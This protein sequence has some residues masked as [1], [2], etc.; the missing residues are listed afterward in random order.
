[1]DCVQDTYNN[2]AALLGDS[3]HNSFG[4]NGQNLET[5]VIDLNRVDNRVT[6]I[7]AG[8]RSMSMAFKVIR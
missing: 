7:V 5:I 8:V 3:V 4:G 6:N 2:V 1:M